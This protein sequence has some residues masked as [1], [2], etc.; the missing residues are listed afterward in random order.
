MG[1]EFKPD[2]AASAAIKAARESAEEQIT[3]ARCAAFAG[4]LKEV[5]SSGTSAKEIATRMLAS[6]AEGGADEMRRRL[7]W[8][9]L[10]LT[11]MSAALADEIS[12]QAEHA[13]GAANPN[14]GL[15]VAM[16]PL[17]P[18]LMLTA[19]RRDCAHALADDAAQR[20][21]WVVDQGIPISRQMGFTARAIAEVMEEAIAYAGRKERRAAQGGAK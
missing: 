18:I 4:R 14:H 3:L 19:S 2:A 8:G 10:A 13:P 15:A 5:F 20:F 21:R 17:I 12:E 11:A 1:D 6:E 16:M 9:A 7:A